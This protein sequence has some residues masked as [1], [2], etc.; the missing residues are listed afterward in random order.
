M[1]CVPTSRSAN[2]RLGRR[3]LAVPV[4]GLALVFGATQASAQ[5]VVRGAQ[6][7]AA[8]GKKAAG[9]MGAVVGGTV[10]GITGGIVGGVKGVFGIPQNTRVHKTSTRYR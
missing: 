1:T 9:P 6:Q 2:T 10:G 7:G 5:G 8:V 4:L 3:L